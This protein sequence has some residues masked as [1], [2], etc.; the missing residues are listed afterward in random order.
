MN[1]DKI[2]AMLKNSD[3]YVSGEKISGVLGVSRA[4]V[5]SAIRSLR[6]EGYEISSATN[7]GY[8]LRSCPE[9]FSSGELLAR[10]GEERMK[11]VAFLETVDSTN[12]YLRARAMDGAPEGTAAAAACQTG[13]RGRLGRSFSSPGGMGVYLSY[14]LKPEVS[15]ADTACLTAWTAEAMCA[16]VEDACGLRPGIKWVNDLVMSRRKVG[17]I[18]TEMSVE[19]ESGAVQYVI[20]GVGINV[21]QRPE[22]FLPELRETAGSLSWGSGRD[23]SRADLASAMIRRFDELRA[24][25]PSAGDKYLRAY[26]RDCLTPGNR[27]LVRRGSSEREAFADGVDDGFRLEVTY[28]DGSREALSSG[29]VSVRGLMG[30]V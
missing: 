23:V 27:V 15:P 9:R 11:S 25:F 19:S 10:L 2:F 17:G 5:N 3:D 29:E 18:L 1:R 24:D 26:R 16:A 14:L 21:R 13:G 7:R 4:A 28:P 22:D 20:V 12:N 8:L 30:Y 6:D